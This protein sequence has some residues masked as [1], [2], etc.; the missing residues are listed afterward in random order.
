MAE[1]SERLSGTLRQ[2]VKQLKSSTAPSSHY[3]VKFECD[4]CITVIKHKNILEPPLPLVGDEC[5]VD[6]NGVE[7]AAK[8][9][10]VG[11]EATVKRAEKDL[12]KSIDGSSEA[13]KENRPPKKKMHL[14]KKKK[15]GEKARQ[16]QQKGQKSQKKGKKTQG[17]MKDFE[18]DIGSPPKQ[19]KAQTDDR[20]SI[21]S[22][23][24]TQ[25]DRQKSPSRSQPSDLHHSPVAPSQPDT[26]PPPTREHSELSHPTH[27]SPRTV[28]QALLLIPPPAHP[29]PS[30]EPDCIPDLSS[31][32]SSSSEDDDVVLTGTFPRKVP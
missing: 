13:D 21:P 9:L 31:S 11:D 10:V 23:P 4:E 15:A 2:S 18:L 22:H 28:A 19:P 6:W 12:L 1:E 20:L 17:K 32:S 3:L 30:R 14:T 26:P 16:K 27:P 8:V 25:Q 5:R 24:S 7:Y 29:A